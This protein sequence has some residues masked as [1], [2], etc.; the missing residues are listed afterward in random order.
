[1]RSILL[2]A[3]MI[4][5]GSAAM[6]AGTALTPD[7]I[8][9]TFATAKPFV[10]TSAAGVAVTLTLKPDGSATAL[11]KG[12][13]KADTGK[14]RLSDNGYCTQWGKKPEHCY[15]VQRDGAKYAVIDDSGKVAAHWSL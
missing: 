6:A 14:W 9:T 2:A 15:T 11:V 5:A 4:G 12:S 1:M 10:A 8:K 7:Q 13:N 3:A